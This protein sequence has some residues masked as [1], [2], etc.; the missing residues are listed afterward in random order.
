LVSRFAFGQSHAGEWRVREHAV[1]N[2]PI[3]RAALGAR[4]IVLDDPKVVVGYVR[5]LWATGTFPDGPD[6]RHTRL[7]PLID[8]NVAAIVQGNAGLLEPDSGGV[9]CTPRR[10]EDVAALDVLLTGGRAHDK[11]HFLS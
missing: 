11:P 8:A 4:Q 9:R 3:A 5:E 6:L 2:Q 1:W 10:N 7:Q